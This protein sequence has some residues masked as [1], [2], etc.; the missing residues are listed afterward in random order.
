[1]LPVKLLEYVYMQKPVIAPRLKIIERYF[2]ETMIK[3]FEP[4]N[5][6]DL[7]RCIVE[8]YENPEERKSLVNKANKFIKKYNWKTQE[9][10][11]LKLILSG[12]HTN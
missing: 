3:Y 4:E 2:D 5:V 6:E 9:K 8:L 11:Y 7:A 10:E 1:M 12:K